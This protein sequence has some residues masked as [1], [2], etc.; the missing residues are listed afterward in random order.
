MPIQTICTSQLRHLCRHNPKTFYP[1][2]RKNKI[3]IP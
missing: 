3:A 1:Q 2:V